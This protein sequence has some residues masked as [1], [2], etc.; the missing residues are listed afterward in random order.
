MTVKELKL[1]LEG[2]PDNM[3]VM[4]YQ[5]NDEYGYS[6]SE[7]ASVQPVKFIDEEMQ[8]EDDEEYPIVDCFVITDDI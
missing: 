2:V 8:L 4:I 3:D 6:M 5:T 1:K 7:E